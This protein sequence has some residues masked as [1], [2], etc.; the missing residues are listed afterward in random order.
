MSKQKPTGRNAATGRFVLGREAFGKISAIEGLRMSKT[1]R[2]EFRALD[3]QGA[4]PKVRRDTLSGKYG[5]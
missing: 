2:G 1:M 4:S 5:K 3:K